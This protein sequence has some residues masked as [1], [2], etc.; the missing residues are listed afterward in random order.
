MINVRRRIA[1]KLIKLGYRRVTEETYKSKFSFAKIKY[2]IRTCEGKTAFIGSVV[3]TK[4]LYSIEP[5]AIFSFTVRMN[6]D[7]TTYYNYIPN[8]FT[9]SELYSIILGELGNTI[10]ETY[11]K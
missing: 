1:G 8:D 2:I 4:E 7:G 5:E 9:D 10:I 3:F 6:E 11:A